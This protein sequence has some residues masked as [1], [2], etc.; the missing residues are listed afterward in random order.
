[1]EDVEQQDRDSV[2][3]DVEYMG[4]GDRE[5]GYGEGRMDD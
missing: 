4:E 1:V 2:S 5:R 3:M